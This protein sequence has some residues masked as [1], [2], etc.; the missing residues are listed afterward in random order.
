MLNIPNTDINPLSY[1]WLHETQEVDNKLM[2]NIQ[3]QHNGY[4][5]KQFG[6]FKLACYTKTQEN[7]N[8][9]WKIFL[10][11]EALEPAVAWFHEYLSHPGRDRHIAGMN[12]FY[13][14]NLRKTIEALRCELCQHHK[15]DGRGM[16]KLPS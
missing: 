3:V 16:G 5:L 2:N 14:I 1:A 4:H 6:E 8:Q 11:D 13:H 7:P 9:D 10:S 15:V 12:R